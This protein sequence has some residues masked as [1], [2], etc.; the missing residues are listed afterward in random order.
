MWGKRRGEKSKQFLAMQLANYVSCSF[1]EVY[2]ILLRI[3]YLRA[4]GICVKLSMCE[5]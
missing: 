3:Q 5:I 4:Q 2:Q 1:S